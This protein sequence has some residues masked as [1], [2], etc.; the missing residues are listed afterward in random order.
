VSFEHT[1]KCKEIF[2]FWEPKESMTPYLKLCIKTWERRLPQHKIII[3]NYTNLNKY[4]SSGTYDI[5]LLKK[6]KLM[7]QKDAVMVAVLEEHGGIFMDADTIALRDLNPIV[8]RL[9]ETEAVMFGTHCAF[10]AARPGSYLL[11]L[12]RKMIQDKMLRVLDDGQ[13]VKNLPW[14]LFSN[15]ALENAMNE[16]IMSNQFVSAIQKYTVD[17][18]A[19]YLKEKT[20]NDKVATFRGRKL[21]HRISNSVLARKRHLLFSTVYKRYLTMLDRVEYGFIP[22]AKYFKSKFM[23][24][25]E[26]YRQFWFANKCDIKNV[27]TDKQSVVGLHNSWTPQWYKDFSEKDVLEHDCLLSKTL[28][29]LMDDI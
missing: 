10:I 22:E 7:T 26:K 2:T 12:W 29:Y 27:F 3:L 16:I 28:K 6:F 15:S 13:D 23:D 5:S 4:I 1:D 14:D 11:Q 20:K 21:L 25:Q 24:P 18:W 17:N 8:S 9:D 19:C